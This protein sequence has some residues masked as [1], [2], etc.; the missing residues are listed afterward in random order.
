MKSGLVAAAGC[1]V[2]VA[3]AACAQAASFSRLECKTLSRGEGPGGQHSLV[4]TP[5]TLSAADLAKGFR[6]TGGGCRQLPADGEII[7]GYV[8]NNEPTPDGAGWYCRVGDQPGWPN[9]PGGGPF[10][11]VQTTMTACRAT[12]ADSLVKLRARWTTP[13][14]SLTAALARGEDVAAEIPFG[15]RICNLEGKDT[16]TVRYRMYADGKTDSFRVPQG[17]CMVVD[18]PTVVM[19]NNYE[20]VVR[21]VAGSYRVQPAGLY[22]RKPELRPSVKSD[23]NVKLAAGL[24]QP[25]TVEAACKALEKPIAGFW[26]ACELAPPNGAGNYRL[27]IAD[28]FTNQ[29]ANEGEYAGGLLPM[30]LGDPASAANNEIVRNALVPGGCRDLFG[31]A[32]ATILVAPELP[33]NPPW[34]PTRVKKLTFQV[35][36]IAPAP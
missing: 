20:T 17:Q 22:P 1:L 3:S 19:L 7:P 4:G 8:F 6:V 13:A 24:T 26:G 36:Q 31:L 15:F 18:R 12:L 16:L 30:I 21:A 5:F 28:G 9:Q 14:S 35:Q 11:R 2:V 29:P 27:C 32:K 34:I 25:T 23:R 10:Y 33:G